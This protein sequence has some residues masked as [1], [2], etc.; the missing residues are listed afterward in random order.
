VSIGQIPNGAKFRHPPKRIVR[1]IHCRK[2][3]LS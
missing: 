2:F 3:V 1:N